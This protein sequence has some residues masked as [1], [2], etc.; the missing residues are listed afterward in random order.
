MLS[1]LKKQS[2]KLEKELKDVRLDYNRLRR[3]HGGCQ[4]IIDAKDE[5]IAELES[6]LAAA[7]A[8]QEVPAL[9]E[10][11]TSDETKPSNSEEEM[12]MKLQVEKLLGELNSTSRQLTMADLK[13]KVLEL[14][15]LTG[16]S[17]H[18]DEMKVLT[19]KL[20]QA[21]KQHAADVEDLTTKLCRARAEIQELKHN[22]SSVLEELLDAKTAIEDLE[23]DVA[24][25]DEQVDFL[26]QVHDASRDVEWV[27]KWTCAMCTCSNHSTSGSCNVCGAPRMATP[28]PG[29]EWAC[30]GCTFSNQNTAACCQVCGT[31]RRDS[32]AHG[33]QC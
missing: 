7:K 16:Q 6:C 3:E 19:E 2:E 28:R 29:S 33:A 13:N 1:V 26:M 23:K 18:A 15:A 10:D 5:R 17:K 24:R 12:A 30:S 31:A 32:G 20:H 14:Q 4:G 22:D 8:V 9:P 25:R 27:S 21:Q 11:P